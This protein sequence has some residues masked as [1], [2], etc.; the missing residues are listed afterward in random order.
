MHPLDL[1][2]EDASGAE[3][4]QPIQFGPSNWPVTSGP[5]SS[6]R[7]LARKSH[8]RLVELPTILVGQLWLVGQLLTRPSSLARVDV[9]IR[10]GTHVVHYSGGRVVFQV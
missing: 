3:A 5:P 8:S 7:R 4:G 2:D 10:S 6:G 9:R 1:R